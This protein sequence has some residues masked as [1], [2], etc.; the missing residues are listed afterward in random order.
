MTIEEMN[1]MKDHIVISRASYDAIT[2]ANIRLQNI[3]DRTVYYLEA[4][5]GSKSNKENALVYVRDVIKYL[6]EDCGEET[7]EE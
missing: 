5:A 7:E 3:I 6:D 1:F 2:Q 4:E